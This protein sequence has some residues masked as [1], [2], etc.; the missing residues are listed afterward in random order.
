MKCAN[1]GGEIK[2]LPEYIEE[3]GAEV[4]CSKCAGTS[5]R[6]DDALVLFDRYS[7]SAKYTATDQ[8][9]EIAA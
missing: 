4:L 3:T 8:E 6:R 5:E 7:Y 2:N 9:L 1:C